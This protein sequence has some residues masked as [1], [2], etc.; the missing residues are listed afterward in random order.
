MKFSRI[1]LPALLVVTPL[2]AQSPAPP[3]PHPT[4]V[5]ADVHSSEKMRF[6]YPDGGTLHGDRYALRNATMLDLITRAY[7]L[8][9]DNVQGGPSWLERDRFDIFARA[10][11]NTGPGAV[12]LM[13]QSL[14]ADRFHLVTHNDTKPMPAY[15]LTVGSGNKMKPSD[16]SGSPG[17]HDLTPPDNSGEVTPILIACNDMS[18]ESIAAMLRDYAGGYLD[19]P[20]ADQTGL[21][22]TWDFELK[23][24]SKGQLAKAGADGISIFNAVDK[25]LGLKLELKTAPRPVMVVDSVLRQPTPNPPDLAKLMPPLPPPVFEVAVIKPSKPDEKESAR[26]DNTQVNAKA[27]TLKDTIGYAWNFNQS[28]KDFIVNAPKWLDT[29]KFDILAKVSSEDVGNTGNHNGLQVDDADLR[30]MVQVL[31]EER[32]RMKVH[33]E[34]RPVDAYT[35]V[36]VSPKLR[37]AD[38]KERTRCVEGPGPDGKDP[39]IANP[40]LGRLFTCTNMTMAEFAEEL[41]NQ[42]P[43]YL[44]NPVLDKTGLE[45]SYDLTLSFSGRGQAMPDANSK[46]DTDPTGALSLFDAVSKQLGL[47]LAKEKRALPVL[48]IDSISETPTEN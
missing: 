33:M 9:G 27:I 34:D 46:E 17:C 19:K 1:A 35:L 48:V 30:H 3:T 42:A 25:Q 15:I 24:T 4:F 11:A 41:Q 21:K 8:D 20:V 26:I 7:G 47:K 18:A 10:P 40:I 6:A 38:P 37:K 45:G 28:D 12:K 14:L 5:I 16:G 32:F 31:L 44:Y 43:G 2:L 36:A 22:G 13:L 29:D 23:W 39:R